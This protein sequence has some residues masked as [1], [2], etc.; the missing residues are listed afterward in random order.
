MKKKGQPSRKKARTLLLQAI[1]QWLLTQYPPEMIIAQFR[2]APEWSSIDT[3]YFKEGLFRLVDT[4][5]RLYAHLDAVLDRPIAQL[6][7]V[8]HA[9]LLLGAWE[10]LEQED[11]PKAVSIFEAVE[12]AKCYGSGEGYRYIHGVLDKIANRPL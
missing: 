11:I 3:Q 12:L 6:S 2:E 10:I 9:I 1:Y 4:K 5:D 7:V 8:E